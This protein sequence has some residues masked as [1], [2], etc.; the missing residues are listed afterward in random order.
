M[1]ATVYLKKAALSD[2]NGVAATNVKR[3]DGRIYA[4]GSF[5]L[6]RNWELYR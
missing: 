3:S 1:S 5:T 6:N 4:A 2:V